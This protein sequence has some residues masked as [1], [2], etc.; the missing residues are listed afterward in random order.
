[1][2]GLVAL[3][4]SIREVRHLQNGELASTMFHFLL[5]L[6]ILCC[7]C[8][9]HATSCGNLNVSVRY[10]DIAGGGVYLLTFECVRLVEIVEMPR[11]VGM[12]RYERGGACSAME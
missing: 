2:L 10:I 4:L 11:C 3:I 5:M 8:L 12:T 6:L 1:M 9:M 7:L